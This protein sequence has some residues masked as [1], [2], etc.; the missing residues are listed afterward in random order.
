MRILYVVHDFLPRAV[1]GTELYTYYLSKELSK[2]HD[3][4]L[5]FNLSDSTETRLIVQEEYDE[6]PFTAI[7][8][9]PTR[10]NDYT[11]TAKR[12]LVVKYFQELLSSFQPDIIH[13]QHILH[14]TPDLVKIAHVRNIP[15]VFTLHDFWLLCHQIK[16]IKKN[17][18]LC[19]NIN[20]IK[21]TLCH[22][23][24]SNVRLLKADTFDLS[25]NRLKKFYWHWIRE[26]EN[27]RYFFNGR[28]R[29]MREIFELVDLFI[30]PSDFLRNMFIRHGLNPDKIVHFQN[31]IRKIVY[32]VSHRTHSNTHTN[33][34]QFGYIGGISELKGMPILIKAFENISSAD[35]HIFGKL[36]QKRK[37]KLIN[38]VSN[39]NIRFRGFVSGPAKEE[40]L[41]I[42]DVFIV[43]SIWFENSPLVIQEAYMVGAPVI[44]SNI[45]GMAEFVED[46]ITG[47]HFRV[48]D[49]ADLRK[50][51]QYLIDNP[52]KV[53]EMRTNLPKVKSIEENAIGM[54]M[55]YLNLKA[56]SKPT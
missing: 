46:G 52:H 5:L 16:M 33:R 48:G 37:D 11:P 25:I 21:C 49:Y 1:A 18:K 55:I 2:K 23:Q 9:N 6:L 32:E 54:E 47:L 34:L 35:L 7:N 45:G 26:Y 38:G 20:P 13:F 10:F 50:K 42:I 15:V 14:L 51:I 8:I 43:P 31:G 39:P 22:Y 12:H 3:V 29:E 41:S 36:D 44:A 56:A 30:S 19:Y 17:N 40:A 53:K 27:F 4:H 28:F 24:N